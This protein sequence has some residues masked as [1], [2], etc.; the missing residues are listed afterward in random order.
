M[1]LDLFNRLQFLPGYSPLCIKS[2]KLGVFESC[3]WRWN[4]L[5]ARVFH[6]LRQTVD[7]NQL[8][9]CESVSKFCACATWRFWWSTGHCKRDSFAFDVVWEHIINRWVWSP[10]IPFGIHMAFPAVAFWH[11][12]GHLAPFRHKTILQVNSKGIVDKVT[13][14]VLTTV[15]QKRGNVCVP[16]GGFCPGGL[17][18]LCAASECSRT[19]YDGKF[20]AMSAWS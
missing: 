3:G 5:S 11:Q 9:A 17:L 8:I 18:F 14:V 12:S 6:W 4:E 16:S 10:D 13:G 7:Q 20:I 1:G 19:R 15:G 2:F